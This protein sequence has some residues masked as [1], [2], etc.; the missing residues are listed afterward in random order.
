MAGFPYTTTPVASQTPAAAAPPTMGG[1]SG[2]DPKMLALIRLILQGQQRGPEENVI[3]TQRARAERL[4]KLAETRPTAVAAPGDRL[5]VPI[6]FGNMAGRIV[7]GYRAR[8]EEDKAAE[9]EAEAAAER[10]RRIEEILKA[11]GAGGS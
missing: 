9:A 3:A 6:T 11:M 5:A 2:M 8:K 4:R 7:S 10:Q 1:G